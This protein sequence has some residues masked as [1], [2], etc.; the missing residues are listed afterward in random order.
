MEYIIAFVLGGLAGYIFCMLDKRM[1]RRAEKKT[2]KGFTFRRWP[3]LGDEIE[4]TWLPNP[5]NNPHVKSCYIGTKGTVE[6]ADRDGIYLR[7]ETG[8]HLIVDGK[9]KYKKLEK[10]QVN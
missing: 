8:A 7:L 1:E 2:R 3:E 10:A 4:L 6:A 5:R 9:F